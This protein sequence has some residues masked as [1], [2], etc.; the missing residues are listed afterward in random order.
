MIILY[1]PTSGSSNPN[2][3]LSELQ[4]VEAQINSVVASVIGLA[5]EE[6]CSVP[7][8]ITGSAGNLC[9]SL[10][11]SEATSVSISPHTINFTCASTVAG[12][13]MFITIVCGN[14]SSMEKPSLALG[15]GVY[16]I[17]GTC[18]YT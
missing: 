16:G 7:L 12:T 14:G 17:T 5:C 4:L 10:S 15:G 13:G 11:T 9:Q 1:P 3:Q 8:I 6:E 18:V 2:V